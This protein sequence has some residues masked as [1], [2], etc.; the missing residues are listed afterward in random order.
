MASRVKLL[1]VVVILVLVGGGIAAYKNV[2]LG[3]PLR[4]GDMP[5]EW[6]IEAKMTFLATGG[7][8]RAELSLPSAAVDEG[9]SP[10]AGSV[11]YNYY[12]EKDRGEY[13]AVWTSEKQTENQ[14][15]YYRVTPIFNGDGAVLIDDR[16]GIAV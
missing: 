14:A 16:F 15:L 13:T 9:L 1:L 3:L 5:A 12:V 7:K 11:G 6:M 4:A 2:T 10:E 8:V